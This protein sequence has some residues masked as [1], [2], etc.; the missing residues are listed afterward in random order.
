MNV[1]YTFTSEYIHFIRAI[2]EIFFWLAYTKFFCFLS[3]K[4]VLNTIRFLDVMFGLISCKSGFL[5]CTFKKIFKDSPI[6]SIK[7]VLCGIIQVNCLS[8]F[9]FLWYLL[10]FIIYTVFSKTWDGH[11]HLQQLRT[12]EI[13][14]NKYLRTNCM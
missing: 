3:S 4:L 2:G 6:F 5:F 7:C 1:S 12:V 11:E 14:H 9:I 13:A 10:A 8:K